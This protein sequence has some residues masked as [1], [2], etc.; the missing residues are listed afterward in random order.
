MSRPDRMIALTALLAGTLAFTAASAQTAAST[1]A[2]K[3]NPPPQLC[4][5]NQ[6][7]STQAPP[8][9]GGGPSSTHQIK[10]NP[11]HYMASYTKVQGTS[12]PSVTPLIPEM[13]D[14]NNQDAI[15]GYRIWVTWGAMERTPG[16]YD[17]SVIDAALARLKTAYNKPKHLIIGLWMY[18]QQG[19]GNDQ[20]WRMLPLY[21][22]QD[23]KYGA[24][25][26]AGMYGWWGQ[27]ANG[28]STGMW[29]PAYY[30]PAVMDRYIALVQALGNHFD[31]DPY[32][33]G[34]YIQE[35]S[36][37]AEAGGNSTPSDP[38]YSDQAWLTQLERLLTAS[39]AAFPHTSVL[40]ANT[41]FVRP[42]ATIALEQ[43]MLTNRIAPSSADTWS[44][45][46]INTYGTSHLAD[47]M[48]VLIGTDPYGGSGDMRPKT[49]AMMDVES[50]ELVSTRLSN[51]GGPW[52]PLDIVNGLN[53][54]YWASHA[55]WTRFP[56]GSTYGGVP[57]PSAA[58]WPNMA[59]TLAK[60]PLIHTDYPQNY[61]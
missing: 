2:V 19:L 39:T 29:A 59:A 52:T 54:T 56:V 58:I 51:Y 3:P 24:S 16:T 28:K 45:S 20:D 14:L 53:Q 13:D 38:K 33:E 1:Q 35:N 12:T 49:R 22:Q 17:F 37:V 10:W 27:N 40:C 11:G 60:N 9:S 6:C 21:I 26:V 46:A 15:V 43:W 8:S 30:N 57:I 32:V 61:P 48:Q 7:S 47:G 4:V 25:P 23:P 34:L 50:D 41:W 31:S 44:Q 42:Q 5:N 36:T 18:G 55:F